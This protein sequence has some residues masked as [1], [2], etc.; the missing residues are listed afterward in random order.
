MVRKKISAI[1]LMKVIAH[2]IGGKGGG[3]NNFSELGVE[4]SG[5]ECLL[6]ISTLL[7]YIKKQLLY[8]Q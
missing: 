3:R 1:N 4:V 2:Q 8:Q 7:N 6:S 5:N